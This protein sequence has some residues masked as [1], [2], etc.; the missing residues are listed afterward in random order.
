[1]ELHGNMQR[2]SAEGSGL[3]AAVAY[4]P[5]HRSREFAELSAEVLAAHGFCVQWLDGCR[6]TPA[7]ALT[8]RVKRCVCGVMV[9][10]SHNPPSD[11]ALKIFWQHGGQLREPH[12][13]E[14][15]ERIRHV[16]EIQRL[17]FQLAMER[18]LIDSCEREI[19]QIYVRAVHNASADRGAG[20]RALRIYFSPLQ[21]VGATSVLPALRSDGFDDIS[22]HGPHA[23]QDPDF[24]GVPDQSANPEN[25]RVFDELIVAAD[26]M[27]ADLILASDPD[28]DRLGAAAPVSRS[29]E[30]SLSALPIAAN[31]PR[32]PRERWSFLTGNQIAA[33]LAEFLLAER[34]RGGKLSPRDFVVKT[35]V[36]T[37]LLARITEHYG[38]QLFGEVL[39]GFKWIGAL[40]DEH[41]PEHFVL[42]TEEAHGYLIGTHIRDKDAAVASM[43][44]AEC[45]AHAKAAGRTLIDELDRIHLKYGFH[46]ERSFS[47]TMPGANGIR[48]MQ[49]ILTDF[50]MQPPPRWGGVAWH[51]FRD[52][53]SQRCVLADGSSGHLEGPHGSVLVWDDAEGEPLLA[54]RPSG[55]E[56]KLKFSLFGRDRPVPRDELPNSRARVLDQL[57]LR[58]RDVRSIVGALQNG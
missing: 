44:L 24:A 48:Q 9:S 50:Q 47:L 28:A 57:E 45:A 34:A 32:Q 43:V 7:L 6:S 5:R 18:G 46:A 25:P 17:P 52:Y 12:D 51:K 3:R 55:T 1:V 36:T 30:G 16:R 11:N 19:D 22:V 56:P 54:L 35:L 27:N 4:D 23:Q 40:V 14:I 20:P 53:Q 8:V 58:E 41:G 39:T 13:T 21:G 42:G 33:I 15:M 37:N 31:D 38:V 29:S 49:A 10:A 26:A 2:P